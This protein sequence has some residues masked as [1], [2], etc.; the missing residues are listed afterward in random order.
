MSISA[1]VKPARKKV[2]ERRLDKVDA[3]ISTP[4]GLFLTFLQLMTFLRVELTSQK[5]TFKSCMPAFEKKKIRSHV[6][7]K[8]EIIKI[9]TYRISFVL[10]KMER[11]GKG[12][13]LSKEKRGLPCK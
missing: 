6:N 13:D 12:S 8:S 3:L 11:T 2:K 10:T 5:D 7:R 9:L 4:K 1:S